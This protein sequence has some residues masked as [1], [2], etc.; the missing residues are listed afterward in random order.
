MASFSSSE[1]IQAS[2]SLESDLKRCYLQLWSFLSG[3]RKETMTEC[4]IVWWSVPLRLFNVLNQVNVSLSAGHLEES[5]F[6]QQIKTQDFHQGHKMP[7]NCVTGGRC[8]PAARQ[9]NRSRAALRGAGVSQRCESWFCCWLSFDLQE[10]R[11]S[12]EELWAWAGSRRQNMFRPQ[13]RGW[14]DPAWMCLRSNGKQK[15]KLEEK[16]IIRQL[17]GAKSKLGFSSWLKCLSAVVLMEPLSGG[18][19]AECTYLACGSIHVSSRGP[20]SSCHGFSPMNSCCN[21]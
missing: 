20:S 8:Q 16:K 3:C 10:E 15:L 17:F 11:E 4:F 19:T 13:R 7:H 18:W 12:E 5:V 14:D 9:V 1:E 2:W 6:A 21:L